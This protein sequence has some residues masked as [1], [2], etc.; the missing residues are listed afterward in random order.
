MRVI[1][2][3]VYRNRVIVKGIVRYANRRAG[4]VAVLTLERSF[5]VF[6]NL[7][8]KVSIGDLVSWTELHPKGVRTVSNLTHDTLM[9]VLFRHHRVRFAQLRAL[10]DED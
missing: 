4:L 6:E 10:L 1:R 5:T 9:R 8:G 2:P 3:L 7:T